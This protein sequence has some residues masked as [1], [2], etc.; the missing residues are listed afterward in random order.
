[1]KR[2]LLLSTLVF[3]LSYSVYGQSVKLGASIDITVS[4]WGSEYLVGPN[5]LIGYAFDNMPITLTLETHYYGG[6]VN[7]KYVKT[8]SFNTLGIG[9]TMR[10]FPISWAIE[11]YFGY[12]FTYE[13]NEISQN[14]NTYFIDNKMVSNIKIKNSYSNEII[15]GVLLSA[16]SRINIFFEYSFVINN[17]N[18]EVV[19]EGLQNAQI[20]KYKMDFNATFL[21]FGFLVEL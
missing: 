18:V 8:H 6:E 12:G 14:G 7:D 1:M 11:P 5:V 16:Q 21:N 3:S 9:L 20:I 10:Y 17:P 4:S 15:L 19:L 13:A 2:V